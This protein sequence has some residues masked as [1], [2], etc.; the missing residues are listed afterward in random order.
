VGA[1]FS[2]SIHTDPVAYPAS[3][4]MGTESFLGVKQPGRGVDHPPHITLR[5][6]KEYNYT[7]APYEEIRYLPI[8]QVFIILI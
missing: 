4:T 7:S 1:R 5:L 2:A 6:K 3:C 8:Q